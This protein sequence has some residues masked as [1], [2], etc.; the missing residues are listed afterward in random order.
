MDLPQ[1]AGT[2][3]PRLQPLP[4]RR[5]F[6][7][8]RAILAL[9]LREMATSYGRSPGGYVWAV[10]E[11][12][13]GIAF[14]TVVFSIGFRSPPIGV[15][16]PIFYATGLVPFLIF[17]DLVTKTAASI[18]FS[19]PLL[20]Y[21]S[22]TFADA[23]LARFILN[24]L[25]QMMVAYILF[26]AIWVVQ[27]GRTVPDFPAIAL[28]FAMLGVVS[29]GIGT[30]NC[31]MVTRFPVYQ[32]IWSIATR[33]LFLVSGIFFIFDSIP[34]PF[35]DILWYN[36]LIHVVGQMRHGFYP[37]YDAVYVSPVYVFGLGLGL[38]AVGLV[39]LGRY[40]RDL[41]NL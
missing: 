35:R 13:A 41:L 34:Q 3:R 5:R 30:F 37:S 18:T 28:A 4:G 39:F 31:F 36:P 24:G 29:F 17:H 12:A 16:F 7:T 38:L 6:A 27:G 32:R 23:L 20:A 22:V 21:P 9:M 8:V 33:P 25:T 14:L 40:Q 2:S 19:K 15:S 10:L 1:R 26:T 11:P